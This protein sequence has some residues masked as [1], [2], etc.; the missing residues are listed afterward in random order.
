MWFP[1]E[2]KGSALLSV[3]GR[4][5]GNIVV[6]SPAGWVR[7]C[8]CGSPSSCGSALSVLLSPICLWLIMFG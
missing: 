3:L 5:T 4:I 6:V 2:E 1:S 8:C 7:H